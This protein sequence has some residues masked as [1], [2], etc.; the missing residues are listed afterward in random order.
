MTKTD[1]FG[2][3]FDE[4]LVFPKYVCVLRNCTLIYQAEMCVKSVN[5]A[6]NSLVTWSDMPTST[7]FP[8]FVREL[9]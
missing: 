6:H 5:Q 2:G 3:K 4:I 9:M 1:N 8:Y 7:F